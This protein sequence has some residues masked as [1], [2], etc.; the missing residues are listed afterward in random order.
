MRVAEL[1]SKVLITAEPGETLDTV[2][3]RMSQRGVHALPVLDELGRPEGIITT[4]DCGP[5]IPRSTLVGELITD[6]VYCIEATAD[7]REAAR[8]MRDLGVHHL[9]VTESAG[10]VVGILSSF[11]LLRVV[12]ES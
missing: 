7:A 8:M 4:S 9:V 12:E 6:Q 10:R 11:D 1:M 3:R 2:E 5:D